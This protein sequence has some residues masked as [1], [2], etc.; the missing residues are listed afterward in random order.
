MNARTSNQLLR[1]KAEWV[2]WAIVVGLMWALPFVGEAPAEG[3]TEPASIESPADE[4]SLTDLTR[5]TSVF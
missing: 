1:K 3:E 2:G 5:E 4:A